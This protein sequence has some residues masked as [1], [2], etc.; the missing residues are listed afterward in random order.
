[1]ASEYDA[2]L[3]EPPKQSEY[4]ALLAPEPPK[5]EGGVVSGIVA[6]IGRALNPI[7]LVKGA[8]DIGHE[9]DISNIVRYGKTLGEIVTGTKPDVAIGQNIPE[10]QQQREAVYGKLGG[11]EQAAALTGIGLQLGLT[12]LPF[13]HGET[14][15]RAPGSLAEVA[16]PLIGKSPEV[17]PVEAEVVATEPITPEAP[18]AQPVQEAVTPPTASILPQGEVQPITAEREVIP[19]AVQE[20][21]TGEILQRQPQ[22]TGATGSERVG[23]E[24]GVQGEKTPAASQVVGQEGQVAPPERISYSASDA[25]KDAWRQSHG[26]Y[27]FDELSPEAQAK[28]LSSDLGE[29]PE[30]RRTEELQYYSFDKNGDAAPTIIRRQGDSL[31]ATPVPAAEA[32]TTAKTSQEIPVEPPTPPVTETAATGVHAAAL[33]ERPINAPPP[34]EVAGWEANR[35]QGHQWLDAG[36]DP[37]EIIQKFSDTKAVTP[38]DMGRMS[39]ALQRL[40]AGTDAAG[41]ALRKDPG[42]PELDTAYR[43]A[44]DAEQRFTDAFKPMHTFASANLASLQGKIPFD[45]G[46]AKS[47][48]GMH[49]EFQANHEGRG[50]TPEEEVKADSLVKKNTEAGQKYQAAND[51]LFK[52]VD[53]ELE[54]VPSK[55]RG[56]APSL[57]ELGEMFSEKLKE[58]CDV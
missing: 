3:E 40:Q 57:K 4:D 24:S 2:L 17:A 39:A 48:T 19:N 32:A 38:E 10:L 16:E 52:T 42:N 22:E 36:G 9:S 33:E 56:R 45:E 30:S 47:F 34:G 51:E 31:I 23:V 15:P 55:I 50:F 6:G 44:L 21:S 1:M 41:D 25:E 8:L 11:R 29:I 54:N 53:K 37:S 43:S 20:P 26:N 5:Q 13:L 46:A 58:V 12:A 18:I 14:L 28:V 49:R 7:N 27:K 35:E